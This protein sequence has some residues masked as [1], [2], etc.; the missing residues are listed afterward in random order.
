MFE[1]Q[2]VI[3]GKGHLLGRLASVVAKELLGGQAIVVVRCEMMVVSGS[4]TRN[5]MKWT[6][7]LRKKMNTNH[8]RGPFHFRAPGK[9][10]WRTVRGMLPHKTTRGAA[11][12]ARL[13]TFEGVPEDFG[14]VKKMVVPAAL[15]VLHSKTYRKTTMLGDLSAECGWKHKALILKLEAARVAKGAEFYAAKKE[16]N[17]IMA[18][19][20]ESA[21]VA[22]ENAVLAGFGYYVE[23]TKVGA[24]AAIKAEFAS[25]LDQPVVAEADEAE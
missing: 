7:F 24:M 18:K 12:L 8:R 3:D 25:T 11:A 19:A 4:L 13:S 2:V 23:P 17:K 6:R 20:A 14:K 9:F 10:F 1:K 5:K 21:N 15:K 16:E 22:K